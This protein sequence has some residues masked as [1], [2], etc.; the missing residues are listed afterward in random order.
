MIAALAATLLH[1]ADW[2]NFTL[3]GQFYP[4]W[5][6]Y[7]L[8]NGLPSILGVITACLLPKSPKFLIS[9]GK[10]EDALRILAKMYRWNH[11]DSN[12]EY[13]LSRNETLGATPVRHH[14]PLP[15][16]DAPPLSQGRAHHHVRDAVSA[17]AEHRSH[18]LR[19]RT[20]QSR[21][22]RLRELDDHRHDRRDP[23]L[24][25][26]A[27]GH[28]EIAKNQSTSLF[29]PGRRRRL[30]RHQLGDQHTLDVGHGRPD[31]RRLSS[32]RPTDRRL[33]FRN[34]AA[35]LEA[36]VQG[37]T[38]LGGE[39]GSCA[40]RCFDGA[41]APAPPATAAAAA[42]HRTQTARVSDRALRA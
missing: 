28:H 6:I 38:C 1:R 19:L 27:A 12:C 21:G 26:C 41:P 40:F 24:R 33:Q 25:L 20:A 2:L 36:Q 8:V 7:L 39:G 3:H 32:R 17:T 29:V 37:S 34:I 13:P 5:R 23:R 31:H 18:G 15:G 9:Q 16:A 14:E 4:T 30:L 11:R 42:A 10:R 35:A 22:G